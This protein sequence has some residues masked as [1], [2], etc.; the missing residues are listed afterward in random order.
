[1]T[2]S[3]VQFLG[4]VLNIYYYGFSSILRN[5]FVC[6]QADFLQSSTNNKKKIWVKIDWQ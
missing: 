3:P 6:L 2:T 4:Q 1:M 5:V